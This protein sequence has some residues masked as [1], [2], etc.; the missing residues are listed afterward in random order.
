MC[1]DLKG[2]EKRL[3]LIIQGLGL[4]SVSTF[5]ISLRTC[6]EARISLGGKDLWNRQVLSW[7]WKLKTWWM[8]KEDRIR[9]AHQ[10]YTKWTVCDT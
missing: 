7:E 4:V 2:L 6:W 5:S 8:V 10:V 3:G 1:C 9:R